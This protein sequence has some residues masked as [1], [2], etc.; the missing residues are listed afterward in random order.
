MSG[1]L[2]VFPRTGAPPNGAIPRGMLDAMRRR[3]ADHTE[4]WQNGPAALGVARYDWELGDGFSGPVLVGEDEDLVVAADASLYYRAEL[5]RQLDGAGVRTGGDTPS[6]LILAAYRAWGERCAER[7][8]GDWAFVLWD[9]TRGRVFC[10]RNFGGKRPLFYAELNGTLIIASAIS[11]ILAYP[12]CPR[13]LNLAAVAA[14]AAALFAEPHETCY[15]AI[16]NLPAGCSLARGEAAGAV[17]LTRHWS[18]P[19]VRV[20]RKSSFEAGAEELRELLCR[21]VGERLAVGGPTSVWL[22]GGRDSTAVFGAGEDVLRARGTVDHLR[23]VSLSYPPGDPGREDE[24]IRAVADHWGSPVHWLDTYGIPLLDQPQER[25]PLRDE[26]FAHA[27]EMGNRSLAA[28]SRAVGARVALDGVGG[29]Q[30]F[31]VS[32]VYLADLLRTGRWISLAR[33]WRERGMRG[34]GW[35][36]FFRE[37]M[38]PNLPPPLLRAAA[39]MRRGRPLHAPLERPL[40]EWMDERFIREHNL[41]E[42]GT[43]RASAFHGGGRAAY[44]TH[45]YLAHPY[46]PRVFAS[47]SAFGLEAGIELRSPL[48]DRRLIEFAVSRPRDER[49]SGRET[50]RLLRHAMRGL[51]PEQVLAPRRVHT[52]RAGGYL[53]RSMRERHATLFETTFQEPLRLA[54]LGIVDPDALRQGWTRYL[55]NGAEDLGVNLFLTFQTELWLR[56]R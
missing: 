35:R 48:Y 47:V 29:D 7:I 17:R 11:A 52:G 45:W 3:G 36:S 28:G 22:S 15:R 27:F 37:A 21:S 50:K 49:A 23:A 19:P 53:T 12:D 38:Q 26:P 2:G 55:R 46:F 43:L 56:G 33:E 44:E 4:L 34:S 42:R 13:E 31:Q 1:I 5:R 18:P 8:E 54:E 9:R 20:A 16:R 24:F 32:G 25:A 30:L 51:L 40:P 39:L 14:D 10:S 6:H 41:R